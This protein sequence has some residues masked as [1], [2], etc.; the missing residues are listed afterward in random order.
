MRTMARI[1]SL[2]AGLA[3]V[4]VPLAAQVGPVRGQGP[5]MGRG[6]MQGGPEAMARNPA[7]VVLEHSEA[8]ELTDD[9]VSALEAIQGEIE[10]QN[11]P[12]WEQLKEAF[13]DANPSEMTAEE[14]QALRDRMQEFA[15]V[16]EEIRQ[17][18]RTLMASFHELLT[19]DQEAQLRGIMRRGPEGRPGRG[20]QRGMH[21]RRHAPGAAGPGAGMGTAYQS[22]F[23]D[24]MMR[25]R[26]ARGAF[27]PGP[28]GG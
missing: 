10:E 23:R 4:A 22:G 13:G 17:T 19:E 21:M 3:L 20:M 7:T 2:V 27:G 9:Q 26:S 11:G 24:G 15:S 6:M 16:R 28:R 8:L 1:A 25:C 18:N 5:A 12:R 14:R